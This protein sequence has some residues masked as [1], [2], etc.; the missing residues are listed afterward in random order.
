M[1]VWGGVG[2]VVRRD[3]TACVPESIKHFIENQNLKTLDS[4]TTGSLR[5]GSTRKDKFHNHF[6]RNVIINESTTLSRFKVFHKIYW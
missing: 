1:R 5:S 3:W 4:K 6:Y 2:T